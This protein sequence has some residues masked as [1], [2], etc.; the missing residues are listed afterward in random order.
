V[1]RSTCRDCAREFV[2]DDDWPETMRNSGRCEDCFTYT[3]DVT[4]GY[5]PFKPP[6]HGLFDPPRE[7]RPTKGDGDAQ[8]GA[9][10]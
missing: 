3:M 2:I 7:W 4:T 1:R 9:Y 6:T 10:A 8:H 5:A